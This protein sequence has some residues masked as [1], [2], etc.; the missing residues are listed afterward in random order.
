[1]E[2]V[3]LNAKD[4]RLG[5]KLYYSKKIVDVNVNAL[6]AL[7]STLRFGEGFNLYQ[8]I[9]LT[10]EILL[11]CGFI[12]EK[13]ENKQFYQCYNKGNFQI[14]EDKGNFYYT[15]QWWVK[16]KHLHSI[17]NLFFA[18]TGEELEINL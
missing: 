10:E 4:F 2:I 6:I 15:A 16:L 17:Q 8:P 18:L 1:M 9:P 5:N 7:N 13:E 11:K 12:K 3:V 14:H